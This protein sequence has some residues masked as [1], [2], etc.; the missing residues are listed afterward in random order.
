[1]YDEVC[2]CVIN[3][4]IQFLFRISIILK[5]LKTYWL[6]R[7]SHLF[8]WKCHVKWIIASLILEYSF[9][10]RISTIL[11]AKKNWLKEAFFW[12]PSTRKWIFGKHHSAMTSLYIFIRS[13]ISPQATKKHPSFE[14]AQKKEGFLVVWVF[15]WIICFQFEKK[16][17]DIYRYIY[18]GI[19]L[20][21]LLEFSLKYIIYPEATKKHPS[22]EGSRN[23]KK[24]QKAFF[25][26]PSDAFKLCTSAVRRRKI[27]FYVFHLSFLSE[28]SLVNLSGSY[29]IIVV[30]KRDTVGELRHSVEWET[31]LSDS[32][33]L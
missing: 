15:S 18:T 23:L 8:L 10:C 33:P 3:Y 17:N 11:I 29:V 26:H 4:R 14:L 9:H 16:G 30:S 2:N 28:L 19:V 27:S 22:F 5:L 6:E 12:L 7:N 1:M 31:I 25:S 21:I 32:W 13:I 20:C 24:G